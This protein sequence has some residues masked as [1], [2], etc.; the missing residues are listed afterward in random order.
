METVDVDDLERYWSHATDRRRVG[1][2]LDTTHVAVSYYE[3]QPGESVAGVVHAHLDQEEVFV[4]LEGTLT[5]RTDGEDVPVETGEA[6]RFAPGDYQNCLNVGDTVARVLAIG[7][8][9]GSETAQQRVHCPECDAKTD[10]EYEVSEEKS[11]KVLR[12]GACG[13]E[14]MQG[15]R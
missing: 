5:F 2:A 1:E 11:A 4:P 7:A 14:L 10:F 9:K 15:T 8:P 3:V 12:C 13:A 6:I